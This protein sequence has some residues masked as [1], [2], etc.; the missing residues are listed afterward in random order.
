[1][2]FRFACDDWGDIDPSFKPSDPI[3]W[4]EDLLRLGKSRENFKVETEF[5][6]T[7]EEGELETPLALNDLMECQANYPLCSS[8]PENRLCNVLDSFPAMSLNLD[9]FQPLND[10]EE[11]KRQGWLPTDCSGDS[12]TETEMKMLRPSLVVKESSPL[13]ERG[14]PNLKMELSCSP[15]DFIMSVPDEVAAFSQGVEN[16]MPPDKNIHGRMDWTSA[17]QQVGLR[18][19]F[20]PPHSKKAM[21]SKRRYPCTVEGCRKMYTK[22]SHLKAH[23]RIH[24]GERP[25]RCTW[26][27][28]KWSFSRSDE[29]TRHMRKHTGDKPFKC[30]KCERSFSRSDHLT[31]HLKRHSEL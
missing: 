17:Q 15:Q 20:S 13:S 4:V 2:S 9:H 7:S 22:S 24:T 21:E 19:V 3:D 25:Y 27:L 1:M 23:L 28:C 26:R 18:D 30:D 8:A 5:M 31:A 10:T 29:L 14:V 16:M 11:A 6:P 12:A